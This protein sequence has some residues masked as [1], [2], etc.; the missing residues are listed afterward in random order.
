[1][2]DVTTRTGQID[3]LLANICEELQLSPTQHSTAEKRYQAIGKWL[4]E[5]ALF[6]VARPQIYPQGSLGLGTT[7]K[8]QGRQEYDLD[9]VCEFALRR[10]QFANPV[11]LLDAVELRMKESEMYKS[12]VSRKNRCIRVTYAND[13]HLDILPAI[14]DP[15]QGGTCLLIPDYE[16]RAWKASNPRGYAA[17]FAERTAV[18]KFAEAAK[19]VDPLPDHQ[20]AAEKEPLKLAVQLIKRQRDITFKSAADGVAPISIVLT[21]LAGHAYSGERSVN[22][23]LNVIFSG[24]IAQLPPYGRLRVLNPKNLNEHL[25]ERWDQVPEAYPAFSAWIKSF[26]RQW[27]EANN[28]TGIHGLTSLLEQLF[29]ETVTQNAVKKQASRI[30]ESRLYGALGVGAVG[31]IT[32][33]ASAATRRIPRNDFYGD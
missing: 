12:M 25:S 28:K 22:D 2:F 24:I 10:E 14:P 4:S 3:D 1:M 23:S 33:A 26:Q 21:T 5:S 11:H 6:R 13:F 9:L 8:P 7:V 19:R 17:W 32:T 27:A 20:N 15:S 30:Q 31:A 29:G 18:R 16:A